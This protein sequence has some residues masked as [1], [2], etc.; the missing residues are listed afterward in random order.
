MK[1]DGMRSGFIAAAGTACAAL[2]VAAGLGA[3]GMY[4]LDEQATLAARSGEAKVSML[5][6]A[7]GVREQVRTRI[8]AVNPDDPAGDAGVFERHLMMGQA[9]I[10][11]L[12][13]RFGEQEAHAVGERYREWMNALR[14]SDSAAA[15]R[16]EAAFSAKFDEMSRTA[17]AGARR[18]EAG[19]SAA[20]AQLLSLHVALLIAAIFGGAGLA[21]TQGV[22][23]FRS[24]RRDLGGDPTEL[25]DVGRRI[26]LGELQAARELPAMEDGSLASSMQALASSMQRLLDDLRA[27]AE[28]VSLAARTLVSGAAELAT[29]AADQIEAASGMASTVDQMTASISQVAEQSIAAQ[30]ISRESD[31]LSEAASGAVTS[32]SN[33]MEGVARST[34][35]L[36]GII[37]TL[38]QRSSRISSIVG[39]IHEIANQTNLL[40]LN[41]AIE[42]ARAG[43]Q[44][45]GFSVVADEVR[46]LADRTTESTHEISGMIQAILEGTTQAVEHVDKWSASVA[47]GAAKAQNAGAR[48]AQIRDGAL[49]V[50]Q[51]VERVSNALAEQSGA[52]ASIAAAVSRIAAMSRQRNASAGVMSAIG[53]TLGELADSINSLA[54]RPGPAPAH[55]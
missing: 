53:Q 5:L 45:R 48:V 37:R 22:R 8:P 31:A 3:W 46:K 20:R 28:Q 43:E 50:A 39:V 2:V 17:L 9:A 38:G 35:E 29:G 7:T 6:L 19:A 16:L 4:R 21:A 27:S 34:Q 41:A 15:A 23:A 18:E 49:E 30:R 47:E 1:V 13:G 10:G 52:S 36:A 51:S 12:G 33:E 55:A 26:A 42:A 44:G 54:V 25:A 11:R 24:M 32:A 40:A 14:A